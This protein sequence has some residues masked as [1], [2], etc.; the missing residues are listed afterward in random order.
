M[1][2]EQIVLKNLRQTTAYS[3]MATYLRI[4]AVIM[5]YGALIH[6]ANLIGLGEIPWG[7]MPLT[8]RVGDVVYGC[9][10]VVTA[11]GLWQKTA[12]RILCFF[13]TLASQFIIYTVFIDYFAF[14]SEQRQ[15]IYGLLGTELI[16]LLVFFSLF[17][18]KK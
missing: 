13:G 12:W 9:L 6:G 17:L 3:W 18:T 11:I 15:T 1:S 7:K 4:L 14:T 16:L 10:D 8:W 2:E 5:A